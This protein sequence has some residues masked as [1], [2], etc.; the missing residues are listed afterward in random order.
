[1]KS[2][3]AKLEFAQWLPYPVIES[4]LAKTI[5]ATSFSESNVQLN[6][7]DW[8]PTVSSVQLDLDSAPFNFQLSQA[9]LLASFGDGQVSRGASL[10]VGSFNLDQT[11]VREFGGNQIAIR[12]K[13]TCAPFEIKTSAIKFV[14][15]APFARS[16]SFIFPVVNQVKISF[17]QSPQVSAISCEGPLGFDGRVSQ[18]VNSSIQNPQVIEKFLADY[19]NKNLKSKVIAGWQ[20]FI[21]NTLPQLAATESSDP[22]ENGIF[23]SFRYD[24]QTGP[25]NEIIT[26]DKAALQQPTQHTEIPK[27]LLTLKSL[28]RVIELKMSELKI[29]DYNLQQVPSFAKFMN[30]RFAQFF[31]WSDLLHYSRKSAFLLNLNQLA[32]SNIDTNNE[33]KWQVK[34]QALGNIVSNR[35]GKNWNFIE[36]SMGLA[37]TLVPAIE[38]GK[39]KISST[40]H[41]SS[42]NFRYG[43][44][45][46][47]RFSPSSPSK[48][49]LSK[50]IESAVAQQNF[51]L[52]LPKLNTGNQQW[53]LEKLALDKQSVWINWKALSK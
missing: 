8:T 10:K 22:L 37:S 18:L 49:I 12:I 1:M 26:L 14:L 52:D 48:K 35:K 38:D 42:L 32:S 7:Q 29:R 33:A 6:W 40:S 21:G 51:S 44:E 2:F 46:V 25:E 19:I 16:G 5:S 28:T 53:Q 23:L 47:D 39:L 30:S 3:A 11:I 13:A 36:W 34:M 4:E 17:S 41:L 31:L 43:K 20:R 24:L 15:Q 50:A 45:Y 9:G 27:L